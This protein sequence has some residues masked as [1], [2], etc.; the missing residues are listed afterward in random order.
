MKILI[1]VVYV[2]FGYAL[3]GMYGLALGGLFGWYMAHRDNN[4]YWSNEINTVIEHKNLGKTSVFSQNNIDDNS[5]YDDDLGY[6]TFIGSEPQHSHSELFS[7]CFLKTEQVNPAID[8]NMIGGLDL[9]GNPMGIDLHSSINNSVECG[10]I[11]SCDFSSVDSMD[12]FSS[13]IGHSMFD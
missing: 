7:S 4:S 10:S 2:A 3:Y 9:G 1:L 8:L 11:S 6:P 12:T 5:F 13:N